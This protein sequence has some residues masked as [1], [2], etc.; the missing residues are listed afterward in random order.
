MKI[1][2]EAAA[3]EFLQILTDNLFNL[4][5]HRA[6]AVLSLGGG[7]LFYALCAIKKV[8]R[9]SFTKNADLIKLQLILST[10]ENTFSACAKLFAPL[11][12][13]LTVQSYKPYFDFQY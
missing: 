1:L 7:W 4:F 5:A 13:D 9:F 8:G 12:Y 3:T 6:K 10:H 2:K 11:F